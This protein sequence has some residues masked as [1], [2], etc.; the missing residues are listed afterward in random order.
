MICGRVVITDDRDG[1]AA[2]MARQLPLTVEQILD[3][4]AILIGS[5][6]QIIATLQQRRER[7]G[8]SNIVIIEPMME[9]FAPVVAALS[10]R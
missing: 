10:G 4:P 6:D 9:A 5:V 3:A 8:V 7:F 2:E 1:A